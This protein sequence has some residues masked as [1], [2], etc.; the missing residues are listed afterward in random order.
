MQKVKNFAS[1]IRNNWKKSVF[2]SLAG[3][4]GVQWYQKKLEDEAYM[5]GLA[6]EALNYGSQEIS[7]DAPNYAVTVILNPVASGVKGRTLYEKYCAPLLNLAG[8]KVS[9]IRTESDGQA[10]D[11]MEIMKD[12]DAVLVAGGDGTLMEVVTGLM[13]RDDR[14][15]AAKVPIGILPVGKTNSL[16]HTLFPGQ[17]DHVRLLGE[18]TMGVI[19]QCKKSVGV[20]EVENKHVG[21]K[22][23]AMNKLE[24]G[25]WKDTTL[26]L[27][28]WF[29]AFNWVKTYIPQ[30]LYARGYLTKHKE[31]LWDCDVDVEYVTSPSE[32]NEG[33]SVEQKGEV[34]RSS[35]L[36]GI[37]SWMIGSQAPQTQDES[38][39]KNKDVS[40][41]MWTCRESGRFHGTG[42]QIKVEDDQLRADLFPSNVSLD[43]F[44][45]YGTS[46]LRGEINQLNTEVLR[47]PSFLI[48]PSLEE[49]KDGESESRSL[50]EQKDGENES[51]SLEEQKD[52]ENKT[53][54]EKKICVD[55]DDI[56]LSGP[57]LISYIRNRVS[58]FCDG[59]LVAK[60]EK[61]MENRSTQQSRWSS[62]AGMGLARNRNFS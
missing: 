26:M 3:V 54:I 58:V 23:Y 25:A 10:K 6:R 2:F 19:R 21:K 39:E 47:A 50:E 38:P 42:L 24:L 9:V 36:R 43:Q 55:G 61:P 60:E 48:D 30:V 13:R 7:V 59:S 44:T 5:R 4:Y 31:M 62:M 22:I 1:T 18:A 17:N 20:I 57:L 12:A 56:E 35:N 32:D 52:G 46:L 27:Q 53:G 45:Q 40:S 29:F 49:Q 28:K 51:G 15:E 14:D 8:L 11:I 37:M 16:A 41:P 34:I 33:D